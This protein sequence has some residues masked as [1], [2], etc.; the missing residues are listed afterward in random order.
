MQGVWRRVGGGLALAVIA[1]LSSQ[2]AVAEQVM[3]Q[4]L[5]P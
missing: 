4:V 2:A 5:A 3:C 1:G